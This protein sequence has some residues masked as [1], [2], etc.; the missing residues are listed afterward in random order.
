MLFTFRILWPYFLL[1]QLTGSSYVGDLWKIGTREEN[2]QARSSDRSRSSRWKYDDIIEF[3]SLLIV[4]SE[5]KEL[6][7]LI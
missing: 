2:I 1:K 3:S 6:G 7:R 5:A 4:D